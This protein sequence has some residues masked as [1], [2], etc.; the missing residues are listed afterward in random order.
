MLDLCLLGMATY[1]FITANILWTLTACQHDEKIKLKALNLLETVANLG[2]GSA[3]LLISL[4]ASYNL[5]L[6]MLCAAVL[7]ALLSA[8]FVA[9]SC[10]AAKI[11]LSHTSTS[12]GPSQ[13]SSGKNPGMRLIGIVILFLFFTGMII[14]QLSSTYTIYLHAHFPHYNFGGFGVLFALNT[15]LVVAFQTPLA[16]HAAR[17]NSILVIGLGAFL[18]GGGMF[19][20]IFSF[21]YFHVLLACVIYTLGEILFFS[22]AQLICYEQAPANKR[23]LIMGIY[24]FVY[25]GSRVAGPA[26]GAYIY[27][28][29]GST[30]LWSACGLIGCVCFLFSI[31]YQRQ[32][33]RQQNSALT[34]AECP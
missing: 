34:K 20:L 9:Q 29:L 1:G 10:H 5:R 23:G 18:L 17:F 32:D 25:A 2:L 8:G 27:Q 31:H 26:A 24:R 7:L 33:P 22:V 13:V 16:N 6:L 11:K 12:A 28:Q 21:T 30:V 15:F 14:A 19:L 4:C 3:A